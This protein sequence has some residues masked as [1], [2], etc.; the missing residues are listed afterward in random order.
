MTGTNDVNA[1]ASTKAIINMNYTIER[2]ATIFKDVADFQWAYCQDTWMMD[3][4]DVS[5]R[6]TIPVGSEGI[7]NPLAKGANEGSNPE[8]ITERNIYA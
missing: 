5:V 6:V 4:Y 2:A 3:S 7:V 1:W 8:S